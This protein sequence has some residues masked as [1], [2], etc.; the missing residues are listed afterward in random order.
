MRYCR[1]EVGAGLLKTMEEIREVLRDNIEEEREWRVKDNERE[2][3][4]YKGDLMQW[5]MRCVITSRS[6]LWKVRN[7]EIQLRFESVLQVDTGESRL[8]SRGLNMIKHWLMTERFCKYKWS[9]EQRP[10]LNKN[11]EHK[12]NQELT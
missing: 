3:N 4:V 5:I 7:W 2:Q 6:C 1:I 12:H 8:L 10:C 11:D 9:I